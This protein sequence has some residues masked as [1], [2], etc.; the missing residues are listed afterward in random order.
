MSE[1]DEPT[2]QLTPDEIFEHIAALPRN[3]R[4]KFTFMLYK[5]IHDDSSGLSAEAAWDAM[6]AERTKALEEGNEAAG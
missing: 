1:P 3:E 4:I 2:Q 5:S 6:I